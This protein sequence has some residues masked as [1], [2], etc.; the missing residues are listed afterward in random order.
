MPTIRFQQMF[1]FWCHVEVRTNTQTYSGNKSGR[2]T[3]LFNND[4]RRSPDEQAKHAVEDAALFVVAKV[5]SQKLEYIS[6]AALLSGNGASNTAFSTTSGT[7]C[8]HPKTLSLR[9]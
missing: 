9:P 4:A 7:Y 6:Q 8:C 3:K 5:Y 2:L 1:H